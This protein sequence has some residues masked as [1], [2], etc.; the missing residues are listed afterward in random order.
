MTDH[1]H[2]APP[3]PA[4]PP[5]GAEPPPKKLRSILPPGTILTGC[6][7][8]VGALVFSWLGVPAALLLGP[9]SATLTLALS[10]VSLAYPRWLQGII[11]AM[12]GIS[13]GGS[14]SADMMGQAM[15]WLPS[16][17][18]QVLTQLSALCVGCLTMRYLAKQSFSTA[19][20]ASY[21]GHLVMVLGAAASGNADSRIVA[22]AQSL[23]LVTL[24]AL[25]PLVL[26]GA[27]DATLAPVPAALEIPSALAVV[28]AGLVGIGVARLIRLPSPAL[29]GAILGAGA[30]AMA[31]FSLGPIPN[32]TGGGLLLVVGT[33]IGARFSGMSRPAL[34]ASIPRCALTVGVVLATVG[35]IAWPASQILG[36]PFGQVLLAYSPGGADV[37]PLLAL[38]QG[39]DAVYV[40][41]H[42]GA[43]LLVMA[44]LLPISLRLP[45]LRA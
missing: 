4:E 10:G 16:V 24:V 32:M 6:A 20:L 33:M 38:A 15:V 34:L 7:G 29:M 14:L 45:L 19:F 11:L 44:L 31:G 42:H 18:G 13:V 43:R 36:L 35:I 30:A 1:H 41:V 25:V 21:P 26:G 40:G 27:S 39:Y 23:R 37:M 3:V 5:Q 17:S 22:I 2:S 12:I 28:I 8:G 9:M